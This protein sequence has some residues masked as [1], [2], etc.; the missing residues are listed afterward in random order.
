V[1]AW[2]FQRSSNLLLIPGT[3]PLAHLRENFA[4][5]EL[6][7]PASAIKELDDVETAKAE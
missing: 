4:A 7:L 3:S 6:K 1:I 2:L 5:V